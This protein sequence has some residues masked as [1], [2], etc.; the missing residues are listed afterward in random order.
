MDIYTNLILIKNNKTKEFEDKTKEIDYLKSFEDKVEI[1]YSNGKKSY[2][3]NASNVQIFKKPKK[4]SLRDCI[5]Y[6]SDIPV[7]E[8]SQILDFGEYIRVI[9]GGGKAEIHHKSQVR[10]ENS[11]LKLNKTKAVFGYLKKL[12]MHVAVMED[13]RTLLFDQYNKITKLSSDSVL[14][15]YLEGRDIKS[16][17]NKKAVI[18]PFGFNISQEKA[19]NAALQNS[20]SI[21]EGPPGT[22]KTQTILNIIA[23][24][25]Y[26][27]K[28]VGVVSGNNSATANVYE[29]LEKDRYGFINALLGRKDK[30]VN[31]FEN[32]QVDLPDLK[33]W[34]LETE[35]EKSLLDSLKNMDSTLDDLLQKHN[36][37]VKLKEK[38]SKFKLEQK[39]FKANFNWEYITTSNYSVFRK[40][41]SDLILNFLPYFEKIMLRNKRMNLLIKAILFIDYGIYK[42]KYISEK[43][44]TVVNS[45]K[46]DYYD[47]VI[48][49][50]E[51]EIAALENDLKGKSYDGL[52]EDFKD[53]SSKLFRAYIEK[54]YSKESRRRYTI[55]SFKYDFK[56]FIKDYPIILSTTN[57]IMTCIPENYLFDYLIIDE[58]SQVDLVTA[59]LALACCKNIVIVGDVKQL[60]QIVPSD[61]KENSDKLFYEANINE[62]YNYSEYSIISSLI[63]LY[64]DKL[65]RTLLCE[66]Y[67]CHPKIIGFCNEKFYDNELVIMTKEKNRDVPLKIYKTA[68]G[69]HARK[70]KLNGGSWD[71]LRQIE[72]IRDEIINANKDKY[73]DC[74]SVGIICP[75]RKQAEEARKYFEN[76]N[77]EIDTVH[78]FQGREKD[79]VIFSTVVNDINPFVDDENLINVAVS[80][81]V[82]EFIIVTSNKLFKRHGSNIGDLIRYIEYNSLENPVVESEKISVFDLLY[83]EYSNKLL[84]IMNSAKNV[85][86]Y[87]SENL[88]YSVI[89]EVLNYPQY[90]SF[91]CVIH[92]PLNSIV[93]DSSKFN[94]EEKAFIQNP[95]THVDFLIFNK[96]DKEPVLV[97]EVDGYEYHMNSSEQRRRD[98]IKDKILKQIDLPILRVATNGSGEKEKLIE[99]LD[100][101]I[102][103]SGESD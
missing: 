65:P 19:V 101:V 4:V 80:R 32:K 93:K 75:Y 97:V 92:I 23:N 42:F 94:N 45:L 10:Y 22:G 11:C 70:D 3:Y 96:L 103:M 83:S 48:E 63:K 39:Y 64:K 24:L 8:T 89:E 28:N 55:K 21:I 40:W 90:A 1:A 62:A 14:S 84:K 81:A 91:R 98:A 56:N 77:I 87:K 53:G 71:N 13:G 5:V 100:G 102:K 82:K 36:K 60:P 78:K 29:K 46:R 34:K 72:V 79:T 59:S 51:K 68:P 7:R 57:S 74:S 61:I 33:D 95:W 52:M 73:R 99:M 50:L 15:T 37:M 43:Q 44:N 17:K 47:R 35:K 16:H 69:N 6:I 30:K 58:A 54:K 88:M 67:R 25:V 76:L 26:R 86:E 9:E 2:R 12:S 41:P 27:D 20:I 38:L 31:F 49:H 85:S 18:F 66:H